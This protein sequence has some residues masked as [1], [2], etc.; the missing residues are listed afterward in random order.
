MSLTNFDGSLVQHII[1]GLQLAMIL[2][3]I[4]VFATTTLNN[5]GMINLVYVEG[6]DVL[7]WICQLTRELALI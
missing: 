3:P 6:D 4:T 2:L 1:A 7:Q 5:I